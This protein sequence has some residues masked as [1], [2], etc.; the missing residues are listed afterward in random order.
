M[1]TIF[2]FLSKVGTG[3]KL[4]EMS[5]KKEENAVFRSL[6]GQLV[7]REIN[8]YILFGAG[9]ALVLFLYYFFYKGFRNKKIIRKENAKEC[10]T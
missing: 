6:L 10:V 1:F 3:L 8:K 2:K 7:I 5:I 9:R 4:E